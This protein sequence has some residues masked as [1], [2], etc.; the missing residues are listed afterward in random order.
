MPYVGGYMSHEL[1]HFTL[2]FWVL[3]LAYTMAVV[4]SYVGLSCVRQSLK[5]TSIR[6]T[7]LWLVMAAV[8]IGGVGIWLMHFIGMMGFAVP[9]SPIR[10]DLALTV[11]SV[12]LAVMATLFGLSGV[13]GMRLLSTRRRDHMV[14][15]TIGGP[16]MGVP[17]SLMHYSGMA[18]IRI[19]GTLEYD[20][21][22]VASSVII[23]IVASTIALW[24]A[25]RAERIRA[26][27]AAALIMGCAVVAM[28]YTGMAGVHA[29]VDPTAPTPSGVTVL[30]L[31]FPAFVIGVIVLAVPIVALLLVADPVDAHVKNSIERWTAPHDLETVPEYDLSEAPTEVIIIPDEYRQPDHRPQNVDP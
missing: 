27:I 3:P 30:A 15:L 10:Y 18:A 11:F 22:F 23:G 25:V 4:G 16:V 26:R 7:T 9:T 6:A 5:F 12:V 24:V 29:T 28:H 19:Q 20:P 17:V 21:M 14:S 1:H 31:L 8:S 13:V 2:G